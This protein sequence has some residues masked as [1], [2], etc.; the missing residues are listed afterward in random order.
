MSDL[1]NKLQVTL[2]CK[3]LPVLEESAVFG[4]QDKSQVV[5]E[6]SRKRDGSHEFAGVIEVRDKGAGVVDFAGPLVHG[7]PGARFLYLSWKRTVDAAA[8]WVQR[9]KVPLQFTVSDL[10]KAI[11]IR[12]DVTERRPHAREPVKWKVEFRE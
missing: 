12:A 4:L 5:H 10:V 8:P 11:E 3:A 1:P 9:I 2:I 6:G 7:T